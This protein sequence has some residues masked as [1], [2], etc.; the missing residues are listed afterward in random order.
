VRDRID[1]LIAGGGA[2]GI[3]TVLAL[4][5]LAA[6]RV[7]VTLLAPE[8]HFTMRPLAVAEPFRAERA[9]RIP[10][11]AIAADRGITLQRDAVACV[12]VDARTVET[13]DRARLRYDVLV[14]ALGSRPAEAIRG[15]L[16]F[17]GTRD[18]ERMRVVVDELRTGTARR[19]AFVVPPGTGWALPL[20]ELAL[21]TAHAAP[22]AQVHLVT[23]EREPL[24]ALGA[25]ATGEIL[26]LFDERGIRLQTA[27]AVEDHRGD[28]L[29]LASG[30][31]LDVDRVVALPLLKGPHVCG[32]AADPHGFV[33][34]DDFARVLGDDDVYAV[35]DVAAHPV[36]QGG[37]A[38][39]QAD[40][41]A[42]AIAATAG[43]DVEPVPYRP[44]LRAT[45]LTGD[46][47]R[48]LYRD[49][50][51]ASEASSELLW[52]PPAKIAGRHLAPYLATRSL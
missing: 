29:L 31:T 21:Q 14:L 51:G 6:E 28:R 47:V 38:T 10:L 20:Y 49:A 37:L 2:A 30:A 4:Q 5:A 44:V 27:A 9:P 33:P 52:W 17:R 8:R 12:D 42:E 23:A 3:E 41:A 24:D 36:K 26:R 19:V 50:N 40:V 48:Y 1:V 39:Q 22:G 11:A 16:T 13:Q 35:G 43:A 15:A 7:A 34:V 25:A 18:A 32:V 45:L 46:G